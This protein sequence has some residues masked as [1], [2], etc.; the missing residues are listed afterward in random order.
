MSTTINEP[1][2]MTFTYGDRPAEVQDREVRGHASERAEKLIDDYYNAKLMLDC[3]FPIEYT[4][5]WEAAKGNHPVLRRGLAFKAAFSALE[6]NIRP[7]ELIVMSRNK[8][9]RGASLVPWTA[10]SGILAEE[11]RAQRMA[12]RASNKALE[13]VTILSTGGGVVAEDTEDLI[14]ISKRYGLPREEYEAMLETCRYWENTSVEETSWMWGKMHPEYETLV[15]FKDA[16]L[17]SSDMEYGNRHGRSVNSYAIVFTL[18]LEG[19]KQ[20][21]RE[22]IDEHCHSGEY[23]DNVAFWLGTIATIEGVQTWMRKYVAE[24]RRLADLET[25]GKQKDEYLAIAERLEWVTENPPR[26]FMDAVQLHWTCQ[27]EVY[28]EMQGSGFS[29]GRLGAVLYPYW[30]KDIDEGKITRDFTLEVLECMRVKYTELE[31]ATST[32]TTGILGGNTFNN[33]CLGGQNPDGS[34]GDNELEMLF[35]QACINMPTVS[36]TLTVLYDGKLSNAFLNKAIECNKTGAGMPAW[37]SNRVGIEYCMKYFQDEGI[38]IEDARSWSVGG[39]LEI[40]P[41]A[42]IYGKVGAGAY[43]SS[44]INF[45]NVPK[46]L[47]LVLFDGKD[48]RTGVQ[49]FPEKHLALDTFDEV[50]ADFKEK[51]TEVTRIFEELYNFKT[52]SA[53]EIDQPMLFSALTSDG[54]EKGADIDHQGNRYNRCFTTWITGQVNAANSLA[55]L[56]RNVYENKAFTL[57]ELK[58]AMLNN[59][60]Y[61][62]ALITGKFSMMEQTK[63]ESNPDWERIHALCLRA[64]KF[65]NDDSYVDDIYAAVSHVFRDAAEA[66]TDVFGHKWV[67]SMLST[68]THGPLG[69][70]DIASPDGRLAGV[71]LADGGQSPYPGTDLNGPFAV[72]NSAV[73]IDHSDFKNTQL[74]MKVHPASIKGQQGSKK[75]LQMIRSFMDQGGYHIQFNVVDSRMLKDAQQKPDQYRNLLV[76]VAGFTQYWVE[77]SKPIQDELIARTEYEEI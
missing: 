41:G 62:S 2:E 50:M 55:S 44:G 56:K 76:R 1:S 28:N 53:F 12:G 26:D 40:Q 21:C 23:V 48:P 52:K 47:E 39:C 10:N 31:I 54:L 57:D 46:I 24:A 7:G 15:K 30:K 8:Y 45:I 5:A 42:N 35:L 32:A 36:P 11:E 6:P 37:V 18:G 34:A 72:L 17:M 33:I 22:L 63:K 9:V 61:E 67:G 60:G 38:T 66:T 19:M 16:V 73:S 4:K 25:E 20:R 68:S 64:P 27:L 59:F 49:V 14:S 3:T 77:V 51:F 71:T 75:M 65:G 69:Q 58:D 70:A 13:D 29:P 43:S 74:N